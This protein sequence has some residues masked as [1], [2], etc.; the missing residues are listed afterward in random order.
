MKNNLLLNARR[1]KKSKLSLSYMARRTFSSERHRQAVSETLKT[2]C[3]ACWRGN[4]LAKGARSMSDTAN[5]ALF[6]GQDRPKNAISKPD[7]W[8]RFYLSPEMLRAKDELSSS[9]V[10]IIGSGGL[11]SEIALKLAGSYIPRLALVDRD[12]VG[13]HN[14]P[15]SSIFT[16]DDVGRLKV[17][18]VADFLR[19]KFPDVWVVPV[20]SFIQEYKD[21]PFES[22]DLII[23]APDNNPTRWYVNRIAVDRGVPALF[24]GVSGKGQEWSGY[25]SPYVPG[26]SACF[27]CLTKAGEKVSESIYQPHEATGD[28]EADR[29]VCGGENI[30]SPMLAP[31]VGAL[32]SVASALAVQMLSDIGWPPN[33]VSVDIK[34]MAIRVVP[35]KP[36][37]T[38]S[39]CGKTQDYPRPRLA[40]GI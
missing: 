31:V 27:L 16:L 22:F 12:T 9:R 10:L 7:F 8:K 21:F 19:K 4:R 2:H 36:V 6:W 39:V 11:G 15:H 14:I 17:E 38:C 28:L 3:H 1:F 20:G 13:L 29:R 35:I 33:Y 18:V 37:A 24:L 30:P 40:L 34:T 32:A 5:T 26:K 25:V 23:C